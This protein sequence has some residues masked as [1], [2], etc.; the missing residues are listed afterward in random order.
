MQVVII[1]APTGSSFVWKAASVFLPASTRQKINILPR[2]AHGQA[3][4]QRLVRSVSMSH[5]K[6]Q[7]CCISQFSLD[8]Q[9]AFVCGCRLE[10]GWASVFLLDST[11]QTS[12]ILTC[13][14]HGQAELHR[15]VRVS[16]L[17][18]VG[19]CLCTRMCVLCM[20]VT[21]VAVYPLGF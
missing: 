2:G 9:S 20:C 4:L 11:R 1:N 14:P 10:D 15:L 17:V 16:V 21:S 5:P 18:C 8:T 3:E 6:P 7:T 13:G 19:D 12:S